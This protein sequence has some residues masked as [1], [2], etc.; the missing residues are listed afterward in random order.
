MPEKQNK[1]MVH[2]NLFGKL[3]QIWAFTYKAVH[4]PLIL[5]TSADLLH[6]LA[7]HSPKRTTL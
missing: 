7:D 4:F 3:Q 2:A 6:F 1:C 5:V